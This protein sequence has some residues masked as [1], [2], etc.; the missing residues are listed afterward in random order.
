[1]VGAF[2]TRRAGGRKTRV[3]RLKN[4][5]FSFRFSARKTPPQ[6]AQL[7]IRASTS[8]A[9]VLDQSQ[10]SRQRRACP[11]RPQRR[12][13][14]IEVV[15]RPRREG[16]GMGRARQFRVDQVSRRLMQDP[17]AGHRRSPV[18]DA[19]PPHSP[20]APSPATGRPS[21]RPA[22][23][24]RGTG[25]WTTDAPPAC[26]GAPAL[27]RGRVEHHHR[28]DAQAAVLRAAEA[29]RV[30]PGLP[31]HLGRRAIQRRAGIGEARAVEMQ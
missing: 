4:A 18:P 30:D 8:P 3:F 1:V 20:P 7:A 25:A 31:R 2:W 14:G 29:D 5:R 26:G 9:S 23:G 11:D 24:P 12:V 21:H 27:A 16:A 19:R 15:D 6:A 22:S 17:R 10:T 28:L 13:A